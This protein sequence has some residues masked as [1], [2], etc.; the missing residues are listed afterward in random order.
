MQEL[1]PFVSDAPNYMNGI[2]DP[3]VSVDD[4]MTKEDPK[5]TV[6]VT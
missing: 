4:H 2:E 5:I 3:S 6:E 1:F